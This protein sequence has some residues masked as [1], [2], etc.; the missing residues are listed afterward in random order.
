MLWPGPRRRGEGWGIKVLALL[1]WKTYTASAVMKEDEYRNIERES[2]GYCPSYDNATVY[3]DGH[4]P[5]RRG[6]TVY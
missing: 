2:L 5:W 1:L 6:N 4:I 3:Q